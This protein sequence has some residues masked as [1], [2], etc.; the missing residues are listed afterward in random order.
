MTRHPLPERIAIV[1]HV[2]HDLRKNGSW[3]GETH[4]QKSIYL[5][6]HACQVP[7]GY[8][9]ILYKH[10]PYS[11]DL[12]SELGSMR[13]ANYVEL[14]FQ[15][16]GYGP[17][18]A[19]T[20]TAE[21]ILQMYENSHNSRLKKAFYKADEIAT[22]LGTKDVK[23]LERLATAFYVHEKNPSAPSNKKAEQIIKLKPHV[24]LSEAM[25]SVKEVE[26][27]LADLAS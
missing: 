15:V 11:F 8:D 26:A 25:S 13:G 21:H 20:E 14:I 12:S 7:L 9:Y 24:Q 2:I 6:Q 23:S 1:S 27:K 4:I 16:E 3:C 18:V 17:T 19:L 5:L 10:G 22:W